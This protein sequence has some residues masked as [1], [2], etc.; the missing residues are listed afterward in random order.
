[1][2]VDI[3]AALTEAGVAIG[4]E[5]SKEHVKTVPGWNDICNNPHV[6]AR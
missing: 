5:V 1:M 3:V 6:E 4:V 2:Y